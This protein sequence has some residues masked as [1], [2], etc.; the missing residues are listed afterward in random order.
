[1]LGRHVILYLN[2]TSRG[3]VLVCHGFM[4]DK[5]D[6]AFMR[7]TLFT[8]YNVMMFDFRAHGENI[9][10]EQCCTFGRDEALDVIGAVNYL[11]Q[12]KDL[13]TLPLFAYGFSMGAVAAIQAQ[14]ADPSLFQA[15]ILDCPYDHSKNIIKRSLENLNFTIFGHTFEIP[16][17]QLLERFAF[18][19]YVQGVL[20]IL[21][22]T[23]GNWD[24]LSTKTHIYPLSPADSIKRISVPCFFIHCQN[25]EKVPVQAAKALY[26]NAQGYKRLWITH[27]RRHFDSIFY[28]PEKYA[29]KVNKFMRQVLN[30]EIVGKKKAKIYSD[31]KNV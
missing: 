19:Y 21:L 28:N 14:A 6:I 30:N 20:K 24:A 11:K 3:T 9:N 16:G 12:R 17:R 8:D 10:D 2:P 5:F 7:R 22:K 23:V 1:M 26:N 18:N 13:A 27:G 15:L 25:D 29:Y 31:F 4:C